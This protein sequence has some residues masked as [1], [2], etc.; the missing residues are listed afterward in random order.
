MAAEGLPMRLG[1]REA[2]V[3]MPAARQAERGRAAPEAQE[4][5]GAPGAGKRSPGITEKFPDPPD[6]G[7][8]T[9]EYISSKA[10]GRNTKQ[11]EATC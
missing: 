8:R 7:K 2:A 5:Q 11:R 1:W 4:M 9:G 10:K 6:F 3:R